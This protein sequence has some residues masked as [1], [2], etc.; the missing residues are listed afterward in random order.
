MAQK[1]KEHKPTDNLIKRASSI[2]DPSQRKQI[3]EDIR[4][5]RTKYAGTTTEFKAPNGQSSV[6]I[7][8]LGT[9]IGQQAWYV[10]RTPAFKNWFGDWERSIQIK[11]F[12]N[13]PNVPLNGNAY[14]GKYELN[15]ESIY[16]YLKKTLSQIPLHNPAITEDIQLAGAGIDK[17]TSWGMNNTAYKKLFVHIPEITQKAVFLAEEKSNR[18]NAHYYKYSHLATGIYIDDKPHTVHIIL[19]KNQRQWYYSHILLQIEKGSLLAGIRQTN[20]GHPKRSSLTERDESLSIIKDTTLLRLLQEDFSQI[21][22]ENGEPKPVYREQFNN[23]QEMFFKSDKSLTEYYSIN[24]IL[25]F[26]FT[27][28]HINIYYINNLIP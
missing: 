20:P 22:D 1:R 26:A 2:I 9:E 27:A 21:V 8:I 11:I 10:I 12:E 28:N 25:G 23:L 18:P 24:E 15:K 17:L 5:L 19:G 7:S 13:S 4:D 16:D 14:Q 6:L 3:I